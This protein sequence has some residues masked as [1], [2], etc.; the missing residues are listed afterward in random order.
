MSPDWEVTL[1]YNGEALAGAWPYF[2]TQKWGISF[3][4]NPPL[5]PYLGPQIYFPPNLKVR[6]RE[7][8]A[9]RTTEALLKQRT[10]L[11]HVCAVGLEP[12]FKRAGLLKRS[13][14][15]VA[16]RQTFLL[17]LDA[18]PVT[19]LTQTDEDLLRRLRRSA[20]GL[21]ICEAPEL[22]GQ[23]WVGQEET[24]QRK[25][26]GRPAHNRA[27]L[28]RAVAASVANGQGMLW[29]AREGET[30]SA[31]LWT[32]WDTD[33]TYYLGST[34]FSGGHPDAVIKLLWHAIEAAHHRG[35]ATFDFE[36]S[37]D[38][39]IEHFF[40]GFGGQL[41]TYLVAKRNASLLFKARALLRK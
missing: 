8:F 23:L 38:A 15:E 18:D 35:N 32:V 27:L 17:K 41:E 3:W 10:P 20:A 31:L 24:L 39:G 4:R 5:T 16:A 37:M 29:A 7:R 25:G 13:G 2:P 21:Q 6:N 9:H 34:Q 30:L 40:R 1:A 19:L 36:G 33:Q 12:A 14:F 28:E 11:P 26:A 22:A